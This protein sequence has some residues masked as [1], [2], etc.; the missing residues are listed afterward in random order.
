MTTLPPPAATRSDPAPLVRGISRWEQLALVING[1]I[2]AG[3]FGLPSKTFALVGAWSLIACAACAA[4]V[5][6]IVLCF[7]EVSSRFERTGGPYLY[8]HTAFGPLAGFEVGWLMWLARITSFA[9][10][11]NLLVTY[12]GGL[13]PAVTSAVGRPVLI[14]A[15]TITLAGINMAGVREAA[16]TSTAF[17]IGKL[18]PLLLLGVAGVFAIRPGAL[19]LGAPPGPGPFAHAM[20]LFVFAYT[21]FEATTIPSGEM[22][23][24][25]RNLPWA[26]L[27][28]LLVV[29]VVY[30]LVQL[31]CVGT[32]PALA[33]SER[34]LAEAGTRVLGPIGGPLITLGAVISI[35][36]TLNAIALAA[37]R[38]PFAMAE[39]GELPG[40]LGVTHPRLHTPWPAIVATMSIALALSLAGSFVTAL[41]ISTLIRLF[42]YVATCAALV[43]LRR[44]G[45]APPA[46]FRLRYGTAVCAVTVIVCAWLVTGSGGR[47]FRDAAIAAA[48]GVPIYYLGRARRRAPAADPA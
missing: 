46:A 7:A 6:L 17:T 38:L 42:S 40:W 4:V 13:W 32:V 2:G 44:R 47:D 28:A 22:Q 43:V 11:S 8:A 23:D 41:T 30:G 12:L 29:A 45:D 21:G 34:P 26:M 20:L 19:V 15:V 3:I 18:A 14:V 39:R 10:L 31:V 36:G 5:A 37:P 16:R 24:P 25:R 33:T 1:V 48:L 9:A 27:T 35:T